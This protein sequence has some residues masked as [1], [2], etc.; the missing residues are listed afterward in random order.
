MWDNYVIINKRGLQW[1]IV[2]WNLMKAYIIF[3]ALSV[4]VWDQVAGNNQNQ[5]LF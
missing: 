1:D 2:I 3:G 5:G 4:E